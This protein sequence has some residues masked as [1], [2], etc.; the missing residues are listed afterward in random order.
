MNLQAVALTTF[1]M[2]TS[3]QAFAHAAREA[4][5]EPAR[6]CRPCASPPAPAFEE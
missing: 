4:R 3:L 6:C 1:M 5:R 2:A